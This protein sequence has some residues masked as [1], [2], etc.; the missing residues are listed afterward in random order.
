MIYP[1]DQTTGIDPYAL[2]SWSPDDEAVS[3]ALCVGTSAGAMDVWRSGEVVGTSVSVPNLQP[4]TPYYLRLQVKF[5]GDAYALMDSTFTSGTGVAHIT[6]PADGATEVDPL[7]PLA[8][9]NV[10][11][12][13]MYT[14]SLSTSQPGGADAY[15]SGDLPNIPGFANYNLLPNTL[16]YTSQVPPP[17][18]RPKTLYYARLTTKKGGASSYVDSTFTTGLGIAHLTSSENSNGKG[19][20][21]RTTSL[22]WNPVPD[23][24]AGNSYYLSL[25]SFPGET[26]VWSSGYTSTT[27]TSVPEGRLESDRSYYVRLWTR[28]KGVW[29]Y[30]D[31]AFSTGSFSRE[32]FGGSKILYPPNNAT[33]VDPLAPIVWSSF[34][35]SS[36]FYLYIG[37]GTT[38]GTNYKN[39]VSAAPVTGTSWR[40]SL[41]G[42]KTYFVKLWTEYADPDQGCSSADPCFHVHTMK[43]T[44]AA[45]PHPHNHDSFYQNVATATAAVRNMASG[46]DNRPIDSTFLKNNQNPLNGGLA[47]CSDFANNLFNQLQN[48][49]IV[50]R[51]RNMV[52]GAGPAS[53]TIVEYYDPFQDKWAGADATF[54]FVLYDPSKNPSTMSTDE[55]ASAL[56]QGSAGA[57]PYQ[58]VTTVSNTPGCPQCFGSFWVESFPT[59]PILDYLNPDDVET[60]EPPLNDPTKSLVSSPDSSGIKGTYIFS[61]ANS[62]DSAVLQNLGVQVVVRPEPTPWLSDKSFGNFSAAVQLDSGWS[63]VT[64]PPPGMLVEKSTCPLFVGQNCS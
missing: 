17:V 5:A 62:T 37:D 23:A 6:S 20:V 22:R 8:W 56:N 40:G 52:F 61:F 3:Y 63:F 45:Q 42:G 60:L 36:E 64:T 44:T 58:F 43:F 21:G 28:K 32:S 35:G 54:G 7:S 16:F 15:Y 38:E 59:D 4:N 46:T 57:I 30:V 9:N 41:I 50:A 26:N 49:G 18:L 53:H 12:A 27:A 1:S 24:D 29:Q 14:I 34:P 48:L 19:N 2:F 55:V 25:G 47:D 13:E 11:D 31:S 51:R 39:Y 10:L 33:N